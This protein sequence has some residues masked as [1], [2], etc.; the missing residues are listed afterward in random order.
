MNCVDDGALTSA[1]FLLL[2]T[3]APY[4]TNVQCERPSPVP[5][6]Q[7]HADLRYLPYRSAHVF[8]L[9]AGVAAVG[10]NAGTIVRLPRLCLHVARVQWH[11]R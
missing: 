8:R 3:Q 2:V 1:R 7:A 5:I 10:R 11:A 9:R 6:F 4:N